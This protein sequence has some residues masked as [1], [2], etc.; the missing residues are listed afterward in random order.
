M[1]ESN[2]KGIIDSCE[3]DL[4]TEELRATLAMLMAQES[5]ID[6]LRAELRELAGAYHSDWTPGWRCCDGTSEQ[7]RMM[8]S[9]CD[10]HDHHYTPEGKSL[11]GCYENVS[12][13]C[14]ACLCGESEE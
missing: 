8:G 3:P 12:G 10:Y 4:S 14:C 2:R 1:S 13:A 6:S 11:H 5:I 7:R 9:M